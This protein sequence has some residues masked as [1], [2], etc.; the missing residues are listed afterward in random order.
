MG[1]Q[2]QLA[3]KSLLMGTQRCASTCAGSRKRPLAHVPITLAVQHPFLHWQAGSHVLGAAHASLLSLPAAQQRLG[4]T[5]VDGLPHG[6]RVL[7]F[8]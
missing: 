4:S 5:T 3:C 1:Q 7:A 8:G 2:Q 6:W